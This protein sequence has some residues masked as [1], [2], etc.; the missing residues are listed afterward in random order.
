[1]DKN[2]FFNTFCIGSLLLLY[3]C[4]EPDEIETLKRRRIVEKTQRIEEQRKND[5][6]KTNN[7]E[8]Q[9]RG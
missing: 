3:G 1:M 8:K 2:L 6:E 4:R 9:N 5:Q 7:L